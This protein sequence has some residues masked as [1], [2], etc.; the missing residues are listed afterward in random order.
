MKPNLRSGKWDQ[1]YVAVLYAA[2]IFASAALAQTP[3]VEADPDEYS[4]PVVWTQYKIPTQ[5]LSIA[6]PK[7]PVVRTL[8]DLCSQTEGADYTAY[9]EQA[10]YEFAWHAK[11][12]KPFP[13]YCTSKE[14]FS[15]KQYLERIDDLRKLKSVVETDVKILRSPGKMFRAE[16]ESSVTTHWLRWDI[17][18]W[19]E[20]TVTRRKND[21]PGED[22]FLASLSVTD[23]GAVEI[24]AGSSR[25]LGDRS[26]DVP[27]AAEGEK[28]AQT[29]GLVICSKP[30]PGYTDAAR[31]D[32]LQ[33]TVILRVTFLKNG[34][35]GPIS[36]EK[37]LP[38]G[39]TEQGIAAAQRISFLP[40]RIN[41]L[42]ETVVR[43]LEYT[44]SIY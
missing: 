10:V 27:K 13:K 24:G 31:A 34:G 1:R 4:A 15:Q 5:N 21:N 2:L 9:A 40:K 11:G 39:L 29:E 36:I 12:D 32:N 35:I 18:R 16:F 17:D 30:R 41:G 42:P 3:P 38:Y 20:I 22:R 44:F 8:D 43:H 28:V 23:S 33:G 26:T 19:L 37:G 7:L 6:M 14:K 25:M